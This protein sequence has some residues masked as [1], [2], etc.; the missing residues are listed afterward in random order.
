MGTT[1]FISPISAAAQKT[2]GQRPESY[3]WSLQALERALETVNRKRAGSRA[4]SGLIVGT[5]VRHLLSGRVGTIDVILSP[6]RA[7]RT[8][9][10][11][12]DDNVNLAL[13]AAD[14]VVAV[15]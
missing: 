3:A 13:V 15:G 10:V 14:E 7:G 5:T 4:R 11:L 2:S 8:I 9:Y 6:A 1:A 12:W